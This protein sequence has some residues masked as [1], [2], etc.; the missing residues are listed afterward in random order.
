M[1]TARRHGYR[2]SP[3]LDAGRGGH[4]KRQAGSSV[5]EAPGPHDVPVTSTDTTAAPARTVH[6]Q[7]AMGTAVSFDLRRTGDHAAGIA[8]AVAWFTEVDERF[9]TYR[10]DSEVSRF[11]RGEVHADAMSTDLR[12]VVAACDAIAA[13]TGGVF[14]AHRDGCFDPSAYVKGWSVERAGRL[15]HADGCGDWTISAGGDVL[16]ASSDPSRSPWRIGVQHPFDRDATAMVL[17]AHDLAVATSGRYERGDHIVDPR[18]G[19]PATAA[20]SSTV[21]GADLGLADAFATAAF[22]LGE[23]GPAWIA[24]IPGY[25]CWTVLADGRVLATDG[26][27]RMV[28]GVPVRTSGTTDPL[29]PAR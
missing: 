2:A 28:A 19:L 26:F 23:E 5:P 25:E 10:P 18:T 11:G 9:S 29:G 6:V 20:A 8:A 16:V 24:A 3:F 15:L 7:R 1:P 22:V 17:E 21:C 13:I 12:E 14:D 27:P 4:R